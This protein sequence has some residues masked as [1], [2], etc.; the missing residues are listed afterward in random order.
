[1]TA[2]PLLLYAAIA[3]LVLW[4]S[5]KVVRPLSTRDGGVLF[6]LP[7]VETGRAL[8][9]GRVLAPIDLPWFYPPLSAFREAQ[10]LSAQSPA[11]FHDQWTQ[12]IPWQR[13]VREAWRAGEWP[14]WNPFA[15]LGEP[16]LGS[17]QP[18]IFH[19]VNLASLLLDLPQA[20]TLMRALTLLVAGLSIYLLLVDLD[21]RAEAAMAGAAG[22]MFSRHMLFWLGW[23]VAAA[24]GVVPLVLLGARRVAQR[25][26]RGSIS[27]LVVALSLLFLAGNPEVVALGTSLAGALFLVELV[28][29]DRSRRLRGAVAGV[30]AL[31][32]ALGICAIQLLPFLDTLAQSVEFARRSGQVGLPATLHS[33]ARTFSILSESLLPFVHGV[34]AKA[35]QPLPAVQPTLG[36][37]W[38][39]ATLL[40]ASVAAMVAPTRPHRAFFLWT[41]LSGLAIGSSF[42]PALHLL[43]I[44]PGL[45]LVL[46]HY[47]SLLAT[48]GLSALAAM[49]LDALLRHEVRR[50]WWLSGLVLAAAVTTLYVS[51]RH[52]FAD[53]G[54]DRSTAAI[55]LATLLVPL[56][57]AGS[58]LPRLR[59]RTSVGALALLLIVG[60]RQLEDGWLNSSF[61][62]RSFYPAVRPLSRLRPAETAD[63]FR[64][65]GVGAYLYP[66]LATMQGF[67]DP[68]GYN[69]LTLTR[70]AEL[71]PIW[72]VRKLTHLIVADELSPFL[73]LFNVKWALV[74][75]G[76]RLPS[77][78]KRVFQGAGMMLARNRGVLPRAF[79]PRRLRWADNA[80]QSLRGVAAL[81]D[82]LELVWLEEVNGPVTPERSIEVDNSVGSVDILESGFRYRVHTR[83]QQPG[84]VV[85]SVSAWRGWRARSDVG[86][87][88]LAIADHALIAFRAPAGDHDVELTYR[89]RSFV[90]GSRITAGSILLAA[91]WLLGHR[92]RRGTPRE[93]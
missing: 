65:V 75:A 91:L 57:V 73:S 37:V 51:Q 68:R 82:P 42:A 54:L 24:S 87:L 7:L 9:F 61:A 4:A 25:P 74:P 26:G 64:V 88:P 58:V 52:S 10:H 53:A 38:V 3:I 49:G 28:H 33:L 71:F 13:A 6:L 32:M 15:S 66:D 67:E 1:M 22:W 78:W 23:P 89:P 77:H 2:T 17:Y 63:P 72:R 47:G 70:W 43:H 45:S 46:P 85:I 18:A 90:W 21:L 31:G 36:A 76:F 27:L 92:A 69:P 81:D 56:L 5:A 48:L 29:S 62:R 50:A 8:T 44:V 39:G 14:L 20:L 83:F 59:R 55:L 84:W 86:D 16:L 19:P 60:E 93:P 41:T 30:G 34:L 79:V 11:L 40:L 35:G 12:L 80:T